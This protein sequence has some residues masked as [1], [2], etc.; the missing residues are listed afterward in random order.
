MGQCKA[1]HKFFVSVFVFRL[2]CNKLLWYSFID[3]CNYLSIMWVYSAGKKKERKYNGGRVREEDRWTELRS[4]R[5]KRFCARKA[6]ITP[7]DYVVE[8]VYF[9][10]KLNIVYWSTCVS[11]STYNLRW[12]KLSHLLCRY[13]VKILCFNILTRVCCIYT[14]SWRTHAVS[15]HRA[16]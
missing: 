14:L 13:H 7:K 15:T 8:T 1:S 10:Y 4:G 3:K 12:D 5:E 6:K 16:L 9:V 11:S 2:T